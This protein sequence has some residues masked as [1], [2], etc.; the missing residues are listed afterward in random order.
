MTNSLYV[1]II[2]TEFDKNT[3]NLSNFNPLTNLLM[4]ISQPIQNNYDMIHKLTFTIF[5]K[6]ITNLGWST[7]KYA[8]YKEKLLQEE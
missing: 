7:T 1:E 3:L 5:K 4:N 6:T 2:S 8:I